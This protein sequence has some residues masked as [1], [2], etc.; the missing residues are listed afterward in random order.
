MVGICNSDRLAQ[1]GRQQVSIRVA[2]A[3][4]IRDAVDRAVWVADQEPSFK[5][6]LGRVGVALVGNEIEMLNENSPYR[7]GPLAC[8]GKGDLLVRGVGCARIWYGH[9]TCFDRA[10]RPKRHIDIVGN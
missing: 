3:P 6:A 7:E 2:R 4:F 1:T 8:G 9:P 10:V 5:T